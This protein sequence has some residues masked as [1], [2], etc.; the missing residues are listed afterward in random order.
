MLS[1]TNL[2]INFFNVLKV[3]SR[4]CMS[5][6]NQKCMPRPKII[7]VNNNEL[8][9]YPYSIKESKCSVSCN[10]INNPYAKLCVPD[11]IKNMNAKVF[12]LM[13]RI[14]ET[15]QIIWH[16]TCKCMCRLSEA[17]CNNRQTWNNNWCRCECKENLVDKI[18]C[19]KGYSWNPSIC[20]CECDKS[21]NIGE[22]FDNKSCTYKKSII[23]KLIEECRNTIEENNILVT[24][25][26]SSNTLYFSLF[27][28]LLVLFLIGLGFLIYFYWYKRRNI[29]KSILNIRFNPKAQ[30]NY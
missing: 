9:F 6:I 22:Y 26:N 16:E 27:I 23:D 19:D 8:V 17:I 11:I 20:E 30:L 4:E 1:I 18:N 14:N 10:S 21:C 24:S 2:V 29:V 3:N 5:M 7:E 15:K 25:S 12:N 13:S 28:M